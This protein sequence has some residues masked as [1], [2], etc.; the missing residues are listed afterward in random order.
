MSQPNP[1]SLHHDRAYFDHAATSPLRREALEAMACAVPG[2]PGAIHDSGR[3]ARAL[4]EDAREE[5]ASLL[6]VGP[7]EI[8]FTSGGTESDALAVIGGVRDGLALVSAVEH[9]AAVSYTHLTLP[10]KRIV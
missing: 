1:G 8:V 4:L 9:P 2:N 3:G 7:L 6:G 5:I 10:T